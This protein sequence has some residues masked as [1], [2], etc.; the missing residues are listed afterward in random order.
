[1]SIYPDRVIE[2]YFTISDFI[3]V[4]PDKYY[5]NNLMNDIIKFQ[6][7]VKVTTEL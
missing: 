1:M 5:V 3:L 7:S 2:I 6:K 4:F